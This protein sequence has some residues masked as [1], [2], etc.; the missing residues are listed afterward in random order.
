MRT[1]P[2]VVIL[3]ADDAGRTA[4]AKT[5]TQAGLVVLATGSFG[6]EGGT[7][8]N[9]RRPAAVLLSLQTSEERGLQTLRAIDTSGRA[10]PVLVYSS[11]TDGATVRRAMIA[12]AADVLPAPV[13]APALAHAV[14]EA[15]G[16]AT[17]A[18]APRTDAAPAMPQGAVICVFGPKG[19]C[20]KT[21]IATNLA[22]AL[23]RTSPARV[24]LVDLSTRFGDIALTYDLGG[25]YTLPD[26]CRNIDR[27]TFANINRYL[28]PHPCGVAL[29]PA[30][31]NPEDWP[32]VQPAPVRRLIKLLAQSHDY[33]VLD[34]PQAYTYTVA[35]AVEE[36]SVSLLVTS[37]DLTSISRAAAVVELLRRR[38]QPMEKVRLVINELGQ[39]RTATDEEIGRAVGLPVAWTTPHDRALQAGMESGTPAVLARPRSAGARS[40][41]A[42]VEQLTGVALPAPPRRRG[43]AGRLSGLRPATA[44]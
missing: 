26:A 34:A 27:L 44:P 19:G 37:L 31:R 22:A 43:L 28:T 18:A 33:T 41:A 32:E 15:I 21:T 6:I 7:L 14:N 5:A 17:E 8:V 36:A 9:E 13:A 2:T 42:L 29:L 35:A 3:D 4:M 12:G 23:A 16:R 10:V 24:A 20:G 38:D 40:L 39:T 30:S 25:H 1:S 11:R